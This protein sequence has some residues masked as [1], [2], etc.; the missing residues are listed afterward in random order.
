MVKDDPRRPVLSVKVD[1]D[2]EE[3]SWRSHQ[4]KTSNKPAARDSGFGTMASLLG[5]LQLAPGKPD[6]K[7]V[8]KPVGKP[9][10]K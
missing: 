10:K 3:R 5:G 2:D 1:L 4:A 9:A 8:G 6:G 7:P